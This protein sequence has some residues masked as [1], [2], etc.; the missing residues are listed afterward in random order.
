MYISDNPE[1]W[2][3]WTGKGLV[4]G[5]TSVKKNKKTLG[6][7]VKYKEQ[8]KSVIC[9]HYYEF[10]DN[11]FTKCSNFLSLCG[12]VLY[13]INKVLN[14]A[15]SVLVDDW[16]LGGCPSQT[17]S[18]YCHMLPMD[19]FTCGMFQT[20]IFLGSLLLPMWLTCL[21]HVV[22]I[23]FTISKKTKKNHT[24]LSTYLI[25]IIV[26]SIWEK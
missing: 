19:L 12:E 18:W 20:G 13:T 14:L 15:P 2:W 25:R 24:P 5:L 1:H 4:A 8:L 3:W 22:S 6:L 7:C 17:Q 11:S 21:K 10:I 9:A 23:K 16:A 26:S